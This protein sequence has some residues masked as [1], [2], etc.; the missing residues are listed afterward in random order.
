MES[1]GPYGLTRRTSSSQALGADGDAGSPR[2]K[3]RTR[4]AAEAEQCV[5]YRERDLPNGMG[6]WRG[7]VDVLQAA[8]DLPLRH[9]VPRDELGEL[10][11]KDLV[12]H[13][14]AQG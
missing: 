9:R 6:R 12:I 8:E 1:A 14:Q 2:I 10:L 5:F 11:R 7:A 13:A 4:E 3:H